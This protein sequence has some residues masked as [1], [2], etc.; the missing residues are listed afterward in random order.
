MEI[1]GLERY[2]S[3][4]YYNVEKWE[5]RFTLGL[6]TA[7]SNASHQK[8]FQIRDGEKIDFFD[9]SSMG[10]ALSIIDRKLHLSIKNRFCPELQKSQ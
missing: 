1:G 6:D 4:K 10:L 5:S 9:F 3:L 7:K 8:K 2:A